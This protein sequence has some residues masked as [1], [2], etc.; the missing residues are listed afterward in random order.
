[1]RVRVGEYLTALQRSFTKSVCPNS[2]ACSMPPDTPHDLGHEPCISFAKYILMIEVY[3]NE[4][5]CNYEAQST[6]ALILLNG[7]V[8]IYVLLG[9]GARTACLAC[10]AY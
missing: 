3:Q 8:P 4:F 9:R 6:S 2:T 7:D 10:L 5:T 1:M